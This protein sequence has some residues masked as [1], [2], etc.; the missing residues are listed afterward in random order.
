MKTMT[1]LHLTKSI[2]RSPLRR[3]FLLITLALAC[4]ALS[5]AARAVSP[6]PDGGYPNNNT[7]EGTN[8]LFSLTTGGANTATGA[9]ALY[10]NTSGGSNTAIGTSGLYHNT[11]GGSNTATGTLAL[12]NNNAGSYNTAN[13]VNALYHNTTISR[14]SNS[15]D[16]A[17]GVDAMSGNTIGNDNAH[18]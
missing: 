18:N 17:S 11:T 8:A 9:G 7:A 14:E 6:A 15:D 1:T 5:P 3:G 2:D 10:S 16:S 13:G 4:F 12:Y